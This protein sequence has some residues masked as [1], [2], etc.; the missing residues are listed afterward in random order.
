MTKNARR[1]HRLTWR[2]AVGPKPRGRLE[3]YASCRLQCTVTSA[4]DLGKREAQAQ[5]SFD[6]RFTC[7]EVSPLYAY[8]SSPRTRI[9]FVNSNLQLR[10]NMK[11]MNAFISERLA[12]D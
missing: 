11:R 6:R 7:R 10:L 12:I 1:R 3:A 5:V 8:P 9:A 2:S 4:P